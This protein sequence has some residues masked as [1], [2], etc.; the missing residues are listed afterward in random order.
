VSSFIA[1]SR[2]S[3][4]AC[5]VLAGIAFLF[6]GF[7]L[8]L[9]GIQG[10]TEVAIDANATKFS[11]TQLAPGAFLAVCGAILIGLCATHSIEFE[12]QRAPSFTTNGPTGSAPV[13]SGPFAEEGSGESGVPQK[14]KGKQP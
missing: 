11:A 2:V 9:M 4:H 14:L 1:M 5:G 10:T 7:G 12:I 3:L 6:L 13:K 8:F